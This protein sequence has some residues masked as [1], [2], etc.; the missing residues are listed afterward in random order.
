[1]WTAPKL[2]YGHITHDPEVRAGKACIGELEAERAEYLSRH[3]G[4]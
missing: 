2:E 3:P 1:M 4:L